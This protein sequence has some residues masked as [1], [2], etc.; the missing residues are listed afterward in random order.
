MDITSSSV[1]MHFEFPRYVY[2]VNTAIVDKAFICSYLHPR[3][4]SS[5]PCGRSYSTTPVTSAPIP[6]ATNL[7]EDGLSIIEL[8]QE[9][10]AVLFETALQSV[11][12]RESESKAVLQNLQKLNPALAEDFELK[13]PAILKSPVRMI[14]SNRSAI[15]TDPCGSIKSYLAVSYCWHAHD[16]VLA[17]ESPPLQGWPFSEAMAAAILTSCESEDVGIWNRPDLH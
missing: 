2:Y 10:K 3:R 7:E 15:A 8:S 4:P 6:Q 9:N 5:Y 13:T 16:W 1:T 14:C 12:A 17:N 11:Q